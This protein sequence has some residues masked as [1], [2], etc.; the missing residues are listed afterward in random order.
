MTVRKKGTHAQPINARYT[1]REL[2]N[3]RKSR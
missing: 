2:K 1:T 3:A